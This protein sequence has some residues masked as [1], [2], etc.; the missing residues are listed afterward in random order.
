MRIQ[1]FWYVTPCLAEH[2]LTVQRMVV[3]WSS[4]SNS[5]HSTWT[6]WPWRWRHYFHS[7]HWETLIH[8]QCHNPKDSA[9][10]QHCCKCPASNYDA[11]WDTDICT[12]ISNGRK[13]EICTEFEWEKVL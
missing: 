4:G 3:P 6:A 2:F 10:Q 9:P 5:L 12:Y 7:E 11:W 13:K 8:W 1:L